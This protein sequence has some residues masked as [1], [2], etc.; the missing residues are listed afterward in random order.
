MVEQACTNIIV[1]SPF[2]HNIINAYVKQD[3]Y[4]KY[5]FMNMFIHMLFM[6]FLDKVF[7]DKNALY[8]MKKH[9]KI[10]EYSKLYKFNEF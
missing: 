9:L 3:I 1:F 2:T 7:N 8:I 6:T 4:Q 5:Y 10:Y